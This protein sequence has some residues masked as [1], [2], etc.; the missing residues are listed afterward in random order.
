MSSSVGLARSSSLYQKAYQ[1]LRQ[2]ILTGEYTPGER[3]VETQLAEQLQVSRT[4]IRE[5]LRQLQR[6][7]LLTTDQKGGLII[8]KFSVEDARQLYDCRLALEL[9]AVR[10]ACQYA[11]P[12][13]LQ[14]IGAWVIR[15]ETLLAMEESS[16]VTRSV[17][18]EIDYSFHHAIAQSADNR[19][20]LE[21]LVQVFAQMT[22]LRVQTTEKK[23]DVL[24]IRTEHR[25]IYEALTSRDL[26][27][28][29]TA[30]KA[31][32]EASKERVA[33]LLQ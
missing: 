30:I 18:L 12:K 32:L 21:L 26:E 33:A 1:A 28:A 16:Q 10:E 9:L 8:P 5:S 17:L 13:Q 23:P 20:L 2:K 25:S 29:Q 3:L 22:L 14:T 11:T 7:S 27:V 15:A 6:E 19:H 4:P 24:E 31:H